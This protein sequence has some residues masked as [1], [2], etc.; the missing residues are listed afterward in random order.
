MSNIA[1]ITARGGSKRIPKKNIKMFCGKPIIEYSIDAAFKAGIY[2]EI[3]VSTDD[4]LIAD[5][6]KNAGANVPFF[7]SEKTSNDYATTADVLMEVFQKYSENGKEFDYATCI[8]P[9]APFITGEKLKTGMEK[10][11]EKKGKIL[12]PIVRYSFPPQRSMIMKNG[13]LLL[14]W[15]ENRN[16]RSQDLEAFYHD[17]GQFYCYDVRTFI[18]QK[19]Q[20]T[21]GIIP[22]ELPDTEV[23]DIDNIE[24]WLIAEMKYRLMVEQGDKINE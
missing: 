5:I 1:I 7:R 13:E 2:D 19:G 10:L 9:T 6:S 8:Y 23:Q 15:P 3:M 4:K 21:D 22:L 17:C 18:N 14:K 24:D 12:M 20:Y 11:K 16:K